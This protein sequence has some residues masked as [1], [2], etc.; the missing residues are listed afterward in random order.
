MALDLCQSCFGFDFGLTR[1]ECAAWVQAWGSIFAIVGS[2]FA[3]LLTLAGQRAHK[4]ADDATAYLEE[5]Q[6]S[7]QLIEGAAQVGRNMREFTGHMLPL[8][9]DRRAITAELSAYCDAFSRLDARRLQ[10]LRLTR[11]VLAGDALT[12]YLLSTF[13]QAYLGE[14]PEER[15]S[16]VLGYN[17]AEIVGQLEGNAKVLSDAIRERNGTP[18]SDPLLQAVSAISHRVL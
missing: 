12:R 3:V 10:T 9:G 13:E 15:R 6:Y 16:R 4:R 1:S 17:I 5:L 18:S 8:Q 2:I 7:Y 14:E 11:A